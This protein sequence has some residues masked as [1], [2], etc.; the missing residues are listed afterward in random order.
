MT[1][2]D[3]VMTSETV[4]LGERIERPAADVY[5]YVADP[6]NLPRWAPGLGT[7][8][9]NVDGE[10]FVDSPMG[11]VGLAFAPPNDYGVLDHTVTT[12]TGETF[13]NPMRVVPYGD[14]CE[15]VFSV[16]RF[17]G[18]SDDDFVRDAGLVA[19]DLARLRSILER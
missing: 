9:D 10:W 7:A 5:A 6:L 4:H 14:G 3:P 16:R 1:A 2:Y 13:Y 19:A 8:V 17:P 11:R 18:V 12:A 15:V